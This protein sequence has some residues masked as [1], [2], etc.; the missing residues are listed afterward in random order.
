MT[1]CTPV[2]GHLVERDDRLRSNTVQV[3]SNRPERDPMRVSRS[4]FAGPEQYL[5]R[6]SWG[7]SSVGGFLSGRSSRS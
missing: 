7:G 6:A 2:I 5:P 4:V 3:R 1:D